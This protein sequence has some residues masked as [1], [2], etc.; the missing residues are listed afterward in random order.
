MAELTEC[1]NLATLSVTGGGASTA[2]TRSRGRGPTRCGRSTS[3]RFAQFHKPSAYNL[4]TLFFRQFWNP[5]I[6]LLLISVAVSTA[7]G[8]V[9]DAISITVAILIVVTVGFVQEY[10]E[11]L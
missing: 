8:Q 1:D 11:A 2:S 7:M 9:D 3:S 10:R 4:V 6:A 5:F